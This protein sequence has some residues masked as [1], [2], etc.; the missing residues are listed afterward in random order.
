M[1]GQV[2]G[3][4]SGSERVK[5]LRQRVVGFIE[6]LGLAMEQRRKFEPKDY[7]P[8]K[9]YDSHYRMRANAP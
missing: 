5:L 6:W 8:N 7:L 9:D 1:D 4:V 3:R 2:E